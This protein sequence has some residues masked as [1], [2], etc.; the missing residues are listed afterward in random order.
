MC[1]NAEV[2][3]GTFSFVAIIATFLWFRNS[4]TDRAIALILMVVVLMQLVEGM[5]WL[6]P[7]CDAVNQHFSAM[8]PMLLYLQP[9]LINAIVAFYAAGWSS[10]HAIIALLFVGFLPFQ[11]LQIYKRFGK[12]VIKTNGQ[13]DWTPLIGKVN[14]IGILPGFLYDVAMLFPFLTLKNQVFGISYAALSMISRT[15]FEGNYTQTWPSLWCHF[16]NGLSVL[17]IFT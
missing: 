14:S 12:C 2:S 5:L 13:L 8:I 4:K 1:Y 3:F 16:V 11:F 9:L 6:H 17:A 10:G 15:G 7:E